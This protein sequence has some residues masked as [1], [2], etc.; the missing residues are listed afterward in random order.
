M[1]DIPKR[2]HS[3]SN[4]AFS[5]I[6]S[7]SQARAKALPQYGR[8][9]KWHQWLKKRRMKQALRRL[10]KGRF[11]FCEMFPSEFVEL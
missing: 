10:A 4:E 9:W 1:R 11:F 6:P 2:I 5:P 7:P 3:P 8:C